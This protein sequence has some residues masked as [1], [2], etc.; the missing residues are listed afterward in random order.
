M[1]T[2]LD[3]LTNLYGGI[4]AERQNQGYKWIT[5]K[6]IQ[7]ETLKRSSTYTNQG[8][9]NWAKQNCESLALL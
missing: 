9:L 3:T 5:V 7:K 1:Q 4:I 6:E 2:K 8:R